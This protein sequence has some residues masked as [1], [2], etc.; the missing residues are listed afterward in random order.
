MIRAKTVTNRRQRLVILIK[1]DRLVGVKFVKGIER[2]V[3]QVQY[4]S[5]PTK[6]RFKTAIGL[7][8]YP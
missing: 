5:P 2:A 6:K 3:S 7:I 1:S 4:T 8:Q